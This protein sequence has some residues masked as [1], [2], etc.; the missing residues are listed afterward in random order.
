MDQ[1]AAEPDIQVGL[2]PSTFSQQLI[3]HSNH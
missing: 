3:I 1:A 2:L